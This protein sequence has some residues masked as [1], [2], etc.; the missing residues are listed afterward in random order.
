MLSTGGEAS[1]VLTQVPLTWA[2]HQDGSYCAMLGAHLMAQLLPQPD[3]PGWRWRIT[4]CNGN[5]PSDFETSNCLEEAKRKVQAGIDAWF[6][7][8]GLLKSV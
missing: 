5:C 8:A 2:R 6:R 4:N 7:D 1:P 3:G